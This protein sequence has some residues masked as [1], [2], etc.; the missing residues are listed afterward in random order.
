MPLTWQT[1]RVCKSPGNRVKPNAVWI[2]FVGGNFVAGKNASRGFWNCLTG[3][4]RGRCFPRPRTCF[5][6]IL[7]YGSQHKSPTHVLTSKPLYP[8]PYPNGTR[9]AH[10]V[11][12]RDAVGL[13]SRG[14]E[15][16]MFNLASPPRAVDPLDWQIRKAEAEVYARSGA[17]DAKGPPA[18]RETH[19]GKSNR[20]TDCRV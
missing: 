1:P 10:L 13:S 9:A 17:P 15:E 6:P 4:F 18:N 12:H 2:K 19:S 16:N 14:K 20:R 11:V 3:L 5:I 8:R 7:R